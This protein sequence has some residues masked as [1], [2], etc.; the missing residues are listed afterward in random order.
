MARATQA[1]QQ[2]E[3]VWRVWLLR[4]LPYDHKES[5]NYFIWSAVGSPPYGLSPVV[6]RWLFTNYSSNF[7][8]QETL[9][10]L[11]WTVD[12]ARVG[13]QPM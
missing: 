1:P 11:D 2:S 9:P 12:F 6:K 3:T 7:A 4:Y 8:D 13:I 10:S 5:F